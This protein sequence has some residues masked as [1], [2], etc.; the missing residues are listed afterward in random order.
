MLLSV[1]HI[2]KINDGIQLL[3]EQYKDKSV[4]KLAEEFDVNTSAKNQLNILTRRM[5]IHGTSGLLGDIYEDKDFC[6]KTIKL[7]KYGKLKESMSLPTFKYCDIAD[8][9]WEKSS[10]FKYLMDKIFAFTVYQ[11]EEK[12]QFLKRIILWKMRGGCIGKR[13][14]RDMVT[15]T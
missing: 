3:I 6:F 8:E 13:C 14:T 5:I 9:T 1:D 15:N 12:E 10:L 11:E 7:D 2:I 4:K